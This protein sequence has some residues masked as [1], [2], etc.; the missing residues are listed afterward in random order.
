MRLLILLV[1]MT[2]ALGARADLYN[3]TPSPKIPRVMVKIVKTPDAGQQLFVS[4]DKGANWE[5]ITWFSEEGQVIN[6]QWS[7]AGWLLIE[8]DPISTNSEIDEN[9]K[10]TLSNPRSLGIFDPTA[11]IIY[12]LAG[13]Y[14]KP[15][16]GV[17]DATDAKWLKPDVISYKLVRASPHRYEEYQKIVKITPA[18]LAQTNQDLSPQM[19][20]FA[21]QLIF[22]VKN[23]ANLAP[24][25]N[26][27]VPKDRTLFQNCVNGYYK[28]TFPK[29]NYIRVY[30]SQPAISDMSKTS[31]E[32]W[33]YPFGPQFKDE[34][35]DFAVVLT[36]NP[37]KRLYHFS[38]E[39]IRE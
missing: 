8:T 37:Q 27:I 13:F 19:I 33:F 18:V 5:R 29:I 31:Y 9:Y 38:T 20:H 3:P 32:I 2:L 7:A 4:Y 10:H 34:E 11:K 35:Y 39:F 1:L 26:R 23:Q 6:F 12:W 25:S 15:D 14:A 16:W 22:A 17:D 21:W 24:F 36:Y 28:A 30:R